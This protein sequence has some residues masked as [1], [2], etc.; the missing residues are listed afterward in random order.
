MINLL[1]IIVMTFEQFIKNH[2]RVAPEG[3][4]IEMTPVQRA[5]INW[6]EENK[7][8]GLNVSY[9]KVKGRI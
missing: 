7:K 2:V 8:K 5:F 3:K 1:N 4:H 6:L 9:L